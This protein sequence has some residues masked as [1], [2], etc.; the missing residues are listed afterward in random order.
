MRVQVYW[1][2]KQK[3]RNGI[4]VK[5]ISDVSYEVIEEDTGNVWVVHKN[6]IIFNEQIEQ[7]AAYNRAMSVI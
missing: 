6:D 3:V 2:V 5:P 1:R 7:E 4:I